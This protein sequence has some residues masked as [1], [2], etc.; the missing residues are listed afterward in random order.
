[1]ALEPV[2]S[3]DVMFGP[4]KSAIRVILPDGA[5][6][7]SNIIDQYTG[8]SIQFIKVADP[9]G[10]SADGVIYIETNDTTYG[11]EMWKRSIDGFINVAWFGTVGDGVADDT[12]AINEVASKYPN[13]VFEPD[14][15]YRITGQIT[16]SLTKIQWLG[17]NCN[18]KLGVSASAVIFNTS[19][20]IDI[21]GFN[22]DC[23]GNSA[24]GIFIRG[25]DVKI[26][27]CVIR[28]AM[29]T[30]SSGAGIRIDA[31]PGI[32]LSNIVINN[33]KIFNIRA[34]MDG[35]NGSGYGAA[36]G[37]QVTADVSVIDKGCFIQNN[38]IADI[39]AREGDG[40]HFLMN[41]NGVVYESSPSSVS[42][43]YIKNCT[44]RY[45]KIQASSVSIHDN[46]CENE[47]LSAE[48]SNAVHAI[49]VI[50]GS[51]VNVY[52]NKVDARFFT[53]GIGV[54]GGSAN[55][56]S[57]INI[58]G[59][60]L[61]SGSHN[62]IIWDPTTYQRGIRVSYVSV[63][64]IVNNVISNNGKIELAACDRGIIKGNLI[65]A[66]DGNSLTTGVISVDQNCTYIDIIDNVGHG[67]G[68][69]GPAM[70]INM[71]GKYGII[72]GNIANYPEGYNYS[73]VRFSE[74]ALGYYVEGNRSYSRS[75]NMVAGPG[76]EQ[77]YILYNNQGGSQSG[78]GKK[79]LIGNSIPSTGNY[80]QGD[81]II[82]TYIASN[83]SRRV[84]WICTTGTR[85]DDGGTWIPFG[86]THV[87]EGLQ[88]PNG[89]YG[90]PPQGS[91]YIRRGAGATPNST[92][93]VKT[94]DSGVNTGWKS[95]SETSSA[96]ADIAPAP[97]T[98]YSQS[99][100][101]AILTELRDLKTKMRAAGLLEG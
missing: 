41:D 35:N 8:E 51:N 27:N 82:G 30:T 39:I 19:N 85:N 47:L 57:N 10:I 46:I 84:G 56:I 70:F 12:S 45:I 48:M 71:N 15:T 18:I 22:I 32:G 28:N 98:T 17:N 25:T 79:I 2:T 24:T 101:Q 52:N 100:V 63:L 92:I 54:A 67:T 34:A 89:T 78:Y 83:I 44:R 62:G 99:Q 72:N 65:T 58:H 31:L 55:K 97:G 61:R 53:H 26:T 5:T 38:M 6:A 14:K 91:I 73:M 33:N 16:T 69:S 81:V 95:L 36:R 42:N 87:Y 68:N 80:N 9:S 64:N 50:G 90:A 59:N 4:V 66:E 88:D 86:L 37:I 13:I 7:I 43:N 11:T 23:A 74:T 94:T 49:G 60:N 21:Q 75:F 40:I 77:N 93:F 76:L 20:N 96:S 1:M 3:D 29:G